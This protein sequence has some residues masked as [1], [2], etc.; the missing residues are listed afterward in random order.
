[1]TD[2]VPIL[3]RIEHDLRHRLRHLDLRADD[4]VARPSDDDPASLA[5]EG[6]LGA[7]AAKLYAKV[8]TGEGG[9]TRF[10]PAQQADPLSSS[11]LAPPRGAAN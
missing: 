7:A 2:R 8:R 4:V 1:M 11:R 3:G 6:M 9:E 10:L 5:G